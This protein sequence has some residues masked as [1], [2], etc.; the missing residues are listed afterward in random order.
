MSQSGSRNVR[1]L[2]CLAWLGLAWL[3][4][5][6][7]GLAWLGLAWLGLAWLGLAWLGLAWLGLAAGDDSKS[8]I[9]RRKRYFF[10]L[11]TRSTP[12][13][14]SFASLDRNVMVG[15]FWIG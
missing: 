14:H 6:W 5:A 2:D 8:A 7:L 13:D 3:G 11:D 4:L 10:R 15:Q 9:V 1:G 12:A